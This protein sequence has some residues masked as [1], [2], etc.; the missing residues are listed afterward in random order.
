MPCT[1]ILVGKGATYDGSTFIARNE[2][3]GSG[4]F[5]PKSHIVVLPEQQ[6]KHY[7]S[8]ISKVQIDL[9][10]KPLRY[11]AM[12]NADPKEGVWGEAG[13]N[14][15]N[16]GM[17]ATETITSNS[18]VLGADP[19]VKSGIGEE[20][21][22]TITLPYIQSAREGVL[23]LG[24]LHEKYGTYEMN[25]VAFSD[26]NEIWWFETVGGHHWIARRVPDD[27]YVVGP[28]QLGIDSLNLDDALGA[29]RNNLCSKDL[30]TF[31]IQNHLDVG[32]EADWRHFD[33]RGAFGS[34]DDSDHSYNTPRAWFMER[35]L[36]PH[37]DWDEGEGRLE[38]TDD[39]LPWCLKPERKVTVE[40][41]KYV[42]SSHYQG[43]P[44]DPYGKYG[45][46]SHRGQFRPIGINRNNFLSLIQIR[47]Y[48]DPSV[49]ALEWITMG[50]NPFNAFLVQ[51]ANTSAVPAY[52]TST[53]AV[54][55]RSFYWTNRLI[56]AL[57]DAHFSQCALEIER[58]QNK[59][60]VLSHRMV[61]ET[62]EKCGGKATSEELAKVNQ[63]ISDEAQKLTDEALSKVL[64]QASC[65]MK[66][67][68]SR[69][70]A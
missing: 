35:Y 39:D 19:L 41:V 20:D 65:C 53:N 62:E 30:K 26:V 64:Y 69:S 43:T 29:G 60:H 31:I 23:R 9:P 5:T 28:N 47:G 45:D 3:S 1:T 44:Y 48:A 18:R 34:R 58:Y 14:E 16:V 46:S 10:D 42:L 11:T 32:M 57:A 68:F 51:Y 13:V 33:V 70:D 12:P 2:D 66:N 15:K 56:G 27:C 22:V 8:V 38:P 24:A 7:V 36:N 59:M 6:P 61:K 21:L 40:D 55:T 52:L 17:T 49:A 37:M 54:D 4:V 50:S 67:G 63:Q 25:G